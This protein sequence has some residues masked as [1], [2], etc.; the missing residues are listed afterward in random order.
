MI[1]GPTGREYGMYPFRKK[2]QVVELDMWCRPCSS[3]GSKPCLRFNHACI[4]DITV[5]MVFNKANTYLL[6]SNNLQ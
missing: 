5:D 6:L 2:S 1:V 3:Y 4:R